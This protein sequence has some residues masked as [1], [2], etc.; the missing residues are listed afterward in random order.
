MSDWKNVKTIIDH[1]SKEIDKWCVLHPSETMST[2]QVKDIIRE[3]YETLRLDL[4][5]QLD[6]YPPYVENTKEVS[7]FRQL[8]RVL[9]LDCKTEIEIHPVVIPLEQ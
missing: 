3:N 7:F 4:L 2:E 8:V 5:E 6:H 9:V 1:F